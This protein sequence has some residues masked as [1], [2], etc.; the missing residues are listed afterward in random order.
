MAIKKGATDNN[1]STFKMSVFFVNKVTLIVLPVHARR[2][3]SA[4]A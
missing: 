2:Q 3:K 1:S 4:F